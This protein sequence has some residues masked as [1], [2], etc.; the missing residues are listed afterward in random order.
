LC[1]G[2]PRIL[3]SP[4]A[5]HLIAAAGGRKGPLLFEQNGDLISAKSMT[6]GLDDIDV[7]AQD[8]ALLPTEV[9]RLAPCG[10]EPPIG[11]NQAHISAGRDHTCGAVGGLLIRFDREHT[12]LS[13]FR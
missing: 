1:D 11:M 4:T 3:K 13:R 8:N 10:N 2:D 9:L 5:G 7:T 6:I 12:G